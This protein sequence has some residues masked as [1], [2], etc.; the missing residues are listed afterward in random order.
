MEIPR[1]KR[2]HGCLGERQKVLHSWSIEGKRL[3]AKRQRW[4][5]SQIMKSIMCQTIECKL[6]PEGTER[7][8]WP[9]LSIV[10]DS[11]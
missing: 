7:D 10:S 6:Y 4:Q 8:R 1:G 5:K 2:K 9:S 3:G 11:L